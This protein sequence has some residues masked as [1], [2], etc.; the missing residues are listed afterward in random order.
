MF[1][2]A[3]GTQPAP[4]WAWDAPGAAYGASAIILLRSKEAKS[5]VKV[6]SEREGKSVSKTQVDGNYFTCKAVKSRYIRKGSE[7]DIYVSFRTGIAKNFGLQKFCEGT[8]VE[9]VSRG[10][11]GKFYKLICK[12]KDATGE[13]PEVK[14]Y[15]A[16]IPNMLTEIDN[17]V[18]KAFKFGNEVEVDENG[19]IIGEDTEGDFDGSTVSEGLDPEE[20]AS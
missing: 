17:E 9:P 13:Y 6:Y 1:G 16:E 19:E 20:F 5:D 12:G 11:K 8:L 7:V 14:S 15:L 18:K 3:G 2:A 10:S 4:G